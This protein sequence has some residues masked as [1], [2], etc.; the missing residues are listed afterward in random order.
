MN[1]TQ[2][3]LNNRL[4]PQAVTFYLPS[5]EGLFRAVGDFGSTIYRRVGNKIEAID[6]TSIGRNAIIEERKAAGEKPDSNGNWSNMPNAGG[7]ASK[8][9]EI[10]KNQYGLD[11]NS[12]PSVNMGDLSSVGHDQGLQV[13]RK[14]GPDGGPDNFVFPSSG[15]LGSFLGAKQSTTLGTQVVNDTPNTITPAPNGNTSQP[16]PYSATDPKRIVNFTTGQRADGTFA[17]A[18]S[19]TPEQPAPAGQTKTVT[20]PSGV[21]VQINDKG[22]IVSGLPTP[23]PTPTP[24]TN[25]TPTTNT[26]TNTPAN[27]PTTT[28]TP[29]TTPTPTN[30][31]QD[32]SLEELLTGSTL[33]NDQKEA[34]RAIYNAIGNNDAETA[35][36]LVSAMKS[37][38]QYSEP[39]FKAQTS[40]VIDALNR[41]LNEVDGDYAFKETSLR[42]KLAD[43]EAITPEQLDNLDFNHRQEIEQLK[44]SLESDLENN[45][46]SLAMSGK[47]NSSV[48]QKT[49][50]LIKTNNEGLVESSTR[51]FNYQ[52][53]VIEGNL[54]GAQRDTALELGYLADKKT[55]DRIKLLRSAEENVGSD[56]LGSLGFADQILGGIGGDIPRKK[57]QDELSF[58]TSF[59][60]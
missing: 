59:V 41:G 44:Q 3:Q 39:Y 1:P 7:Q 60:F 38:A 37:A 58:A 9:L 11:W 42:N 56:A 21:Q 27:T 2:Q 15:D 53:D 8:A 54:E 17:P 48:R 43:L 29:A 4:N 46:Q 47:T 6:L 52:T 50:S 30:T 33:S 20:L 24:N 55:Q 31:P 36:R 32:V 18:G 10:L 28:T 40:L 26:T 45:A 57:L 25:N 49:D 13:Y 12:L 19:F 22:D 23:T 5:T 51:K 14:A 35:D 16:A 34:I